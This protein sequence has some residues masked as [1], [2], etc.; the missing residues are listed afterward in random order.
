MANGHLSMSMA[1]S[2]PAYLQLSLWR[3]HGL[4]L[5]D[6]HGRLTYA[7]VAARSEL[8]TGATLIDMNGALGAAQPLQA[9]ALARG[10]QAARRGRETMLELGPAARTRL[11]VLQPFARDRLAPQGDVLIVCEKDEGAELRSLR[12]Y[13]ESIG[14]T[15]SEF[16]V[17]RLLSQG[18]GVEDIAE[19]RRVKL[20][21][22]RS[23]VLRIREKA[24]SPSIAHMI[25]RMSRLPVCL[26]T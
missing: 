8:A 3:S 10:L 2:H 1:P 7:N 15:D 24:G 5:L 12:L 26:S 4:I 25:A 9:T 14:L 13:A 23:Q 22:V 20:T 21:T 6:A 19:R 16:D 11:F 18:V 17:V